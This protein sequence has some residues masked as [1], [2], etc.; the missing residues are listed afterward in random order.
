MLVFRISLKAAKQLNQQK[1]RNNKSCYPEQARA[2][3]PKIVAKCQKSPSEAKEESLE[4][5]CEIKAIHAA[6]P[7]GFEPSAF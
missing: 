2:V 5:L 1:K 7:G 6:R 4:S 3:V